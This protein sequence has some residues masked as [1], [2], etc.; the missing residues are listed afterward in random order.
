M[1]SPGGCQ[2]SP[3]E[4]VRGLGCQ[5]VDLDAAERRIDE[6]AAEASHKKTMMK[7]LLMIYT[8]EAEDAKRASDP[9]VDAAVMAEYMT[10]T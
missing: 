6:R 4:N 8:S 3:P 1:E 9:A 2:G 7:Y 5:P 10:Y